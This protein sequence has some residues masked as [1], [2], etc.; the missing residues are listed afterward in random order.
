MSKNPQ[1]HKFIHFCEA[2]NFSDRTNLLSSLQRMGYGVFYKISILESIR[3]IRSD[4]VCHK[5]RIYQ[6]EVSTET[7]FYLRKMREFSKKVTFTNSEK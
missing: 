3:R 2:I 5:T 1:S 6:S 4:E 7:G